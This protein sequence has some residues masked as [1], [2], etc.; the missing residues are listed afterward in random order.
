MP[1][2]LNEQLATKRYDAWALLIIA[3]ALICANAW[4]VWHDGV[5]RR[6]LSALSEPPVGSRLPALKGVD[7]HGGTVEVNYGEDHR[8]TLLLVFSRTCRVCEMNWSAWSS[9]LSAVNP[10]QLRVVYVDL[11]SKPDSTHLARHRAPADSL[12]TGPDP[13]TALIA[14]NIRLTPQTILITQE[15]RVLGVWPGLLKGRRMGS[16]LSALRSP[17]R[18]RFARGAPAAR[19]VVLSVPTAD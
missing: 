4:L 13:A 14:Y 11:S 9:A 16:L 15:G 3:S 6:K 18:G 1:A 7:P 8:K 19:V 10:S 17:G 2:S 12:V 5:L